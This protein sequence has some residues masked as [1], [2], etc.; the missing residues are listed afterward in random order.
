MVH[1]EPW[2]MFCGNMT[3]L[4]LSH[5]ADGNLFGVSD[6]HSFLLEINCKSRL[7]F[8]RTAVHLLIS[9]LVLASL[10]VTS[11]ITTCQSC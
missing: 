8:L 5:S 9:L 3:G 6:F 2:S 11:I 4:W 10:T 7:W 1:W